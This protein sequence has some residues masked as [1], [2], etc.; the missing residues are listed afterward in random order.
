MRMKSV[1]A[2]LCLGIGL[3]N[4]GC[5][6]VSTFD[7]FSGGNS[8]TI[9]DG[10]FPTP[11]VGC[12]S[13]V[14]YGPTPVSCVSKP[15]VDCPSPVPAGPTP[16]SCLSNPVIG[17]PSP[18]PF[19]P[20]PVSCAPKPPIGC[21]SPV[22]AGP[23]PVSCPPTPVSLGNAIPHFTPNIYANCRL[24]ASSLY[25]LVFTVIPGTQAEVI[26]RHQTE[27]GWWYFVHLPN[28]QECWMFERSGSLEGDPNLIPLK[29][30]PP[31]PTKPSGGSGCNLN[32]A[33]CRQQKLY[34][35]QST[36][37]CLSRGV[38]CP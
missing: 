24:G 26:G 5:A 37:S 32:D 23:T 38:V 18:V 29:L 22:P 30:P 17:C 21:P 15:Q 6:G 2:F 7:P 9:Q 8:S 25:G 10:A 3:L 13:P 1:I 19:G 34:F 4:S 35:C 31:L 12:P 11:V 20:T 33:I 14:P 16:L 27:D 36:C 28:N